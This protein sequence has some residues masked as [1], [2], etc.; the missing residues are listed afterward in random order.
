MSWGLGLD[1]II[2]KLEQSVLGK[3]PKQIVRF[4]DANGTLRGFHKEGTF[5]L[6]DPRGPFVE[7]H[8]GALRLIH[9]GAA[10]LGMGPCQP[11]GWVLA[12]RTR[13]LV[14]VL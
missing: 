14:R 6:L 5:Y 12:W 7:Y 4:T 8:V 2:T 11:D 13:V 10:Y 9:F 3:G 1:S